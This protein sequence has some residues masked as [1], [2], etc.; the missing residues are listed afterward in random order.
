MF[1]KVRFN[2]YHPAGTKYQI[3]SLTDLKSKELIKLD[4]DWQM[5]VSCF[6]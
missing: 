1:G 2:I 3:F 4:F 5:P 6:T